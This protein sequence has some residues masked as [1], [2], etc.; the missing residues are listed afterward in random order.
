M[1][2]FEQASREKLRFSTPVGNVSVEDL[3]DLPLT[4]VRGLD[5]H[6]IA[7]D[8]QTE[9]NKEPAKSLDFFAFA[10][11]KNLTLQLKFDIVKHIVTT[12]VAENHAKSEQAAKDS[13][14]EQIKA[15]IAEKKQEDL[16]SKSVEELEALL[17]A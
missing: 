6:K 15:L 14:R 5:L 2:I 3:W 7:L 17:N 4:S 8:L 9:L 1:N 16:K 11:A 12:K 13:Q 10:P